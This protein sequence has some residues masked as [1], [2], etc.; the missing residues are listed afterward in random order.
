MIET[1]TDDGTTETATTPAKRTRRSPAEMA[2]ERSKEAMSD[3]S[4]KL[5]PIDT[6]TMMVSN[7]VSPS[8]YS[9]IYCVLE[10]CA[11]IKAQYNLS[12]EALLALIAKFKAPD[13][14]KRK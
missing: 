1:E 14:P 5:T 3:P 4:F 12:D 11:A 2:A 10:D 13:T 8:D 6:I 9:D 7:S